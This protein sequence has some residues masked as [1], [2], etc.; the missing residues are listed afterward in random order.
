M[1][2]ENCSKNAEFTI[3]FTN[4]ASYLVSLTKRVSISLFLRFRMILS[5]QPV[6]ITFTVNR[7][8]NWQISRN[9][10]IINRYNNQAGLEG[11]A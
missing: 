8:Y 11:I 5:V 7:P 6:I 3:F 2:R 10:L 4:F 9:C 1:G